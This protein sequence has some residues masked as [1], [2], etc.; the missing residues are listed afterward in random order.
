L[1][2]VIN[3][4]SGQARF[5]RQVRPKNEA[6][7]RSDQRK[8]EGTTISINDVKS[9]CKFFILK[10]FII[11]FLYLDLALS[12]LSEVYYIPADFENFTKYKRVDKN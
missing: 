12:K 8:Q 2:H 4:R 3:Y 5:L 6:L 9:K 10:F 1:K 11:F 7:S